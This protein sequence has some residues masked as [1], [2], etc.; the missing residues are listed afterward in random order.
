MVFRGIISLLFLFLVGCKNPLGSSGSSQVQEGFQPGVPG[1]TTPALQNFEFDFDFNSPSDYDLSPG[2]AIVG[3]AAQLVE[4]DVI[5]DSTNTGG[6]DLNFSDATS[7]DGN[8]QAASNQV[9]L[10]SGN[11]GEFISRIMDNILATGSWTRLNFITSLPFGKEL[12]TTGE[13]GYG[14]PVADFSNGLVGLWHL[15]EMGGA[16]VVDDSS[17]SQND[18]TPMNGVVLGGGGQLG[19]GAYFDGVDDFIQLSGTGFATGNSPRTTAL[20]FRKDVGSGNRNLIAYGANG[21][22]NLWEMMAYGGHV[23]LHAYGGGFDTLGISA[24]IVENTWTHAAITYSGTHVTIYVNGV[25]RGT[26][27][28]ALA[29]SNSFFNIG[30]PGYFTNW[31][32]DLDEVGLWNRAL[33]D[34]E[35]EQMYR[36][37]AHRVKFQVR[38]CSDT[39][40]ATNP[41]WVGPSGTN[42]DYFSELNNN[43]QPYS[44]LGNVVDEPFSVSWND[45]GV[46]NPTFETWRA[47][48]VALPFMQYKLRLESDTTAFYPDV[49]SVSFSPDSGYVTTSPSI[50]SQSTVAP[51]FIQLR[52][53][54]ITESGSC[55]GIHYDIGNAHHQFYSW[56]GGGWTSS[57][58]Y[59]SAT[60]KSHLESLSEA[61]WKLF[62]QGTGRVY[63]RAFLPSTGASTCQ[64]QNIKIF[65]AR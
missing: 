10:S 24:P 12:V 53:I 29:T 38:G 2:V 59:S 14:M 50:V 63:V 61:Q 7:L 58:T 13:T 28:L 57:S 18:G 39:T 11:S 1:S 33:S 47:T 27:P 6:A 19:R 21:N 9:T 23:I 37:G 36:R 40:C 25:N 44:Y 8:V 46:L 54:Q 56:S 64:L 55:G 30:G 43:T 45:L 34:S 4:R 48:N 65:G 49:T 5:D 22:G 41:V 52:G 35:I 31:K 51:Q 3:G 16:T 20:W 26:M 62:P 42:A 60:S 15:N 32:G 17:S